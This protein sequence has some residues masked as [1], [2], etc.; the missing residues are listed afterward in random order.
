MSNTVTAPSSFNVNFCNV[1]GLDT[2]L[3]AAR[4]DGVTLVSVK[5]TYSGYRI[6]LVL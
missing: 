1:R 2:N 3:N 4:L 5:V 6:N